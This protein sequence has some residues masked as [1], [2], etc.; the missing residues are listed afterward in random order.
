MHDT[1]LRRLYTVEEAALLVGVAR[2]TM[3][4]RVATGDMPATRLGR[5]V[6]ITAAALE[7]LL[8]EPPPTTSELAAARRQIR[9][10]SP[11]PSPPPSS[12]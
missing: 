9:D 1:P 2:S 7:A 11:P 3:Y 10:Q 12:E 6:Y 5:R 4:E 8:G